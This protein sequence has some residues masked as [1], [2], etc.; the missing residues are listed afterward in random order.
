[1]NIYIHIYSAEAYT[2]SHIFINYLG[3]CYYLLLLEYFCL[4]VFLKFILL[5]S[6]H[7][8]HCSMLFLSCYPSGLSH[9]RT[10]ERTIIS[11]CSTNEK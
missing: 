4:F 1:M 8:Q 2:I 11:I 6:N 5:F 7:L 9:A 3:D 10:E